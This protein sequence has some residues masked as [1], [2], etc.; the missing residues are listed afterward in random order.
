MFF[1]FVFFFLPSSS[2]G[3]ESYETYRNPALLHRKSG[4]TT[5]YPALRLDAVCWEN[6]LNFI[7]N[8]EFK[9]FVCFL[10]VQKAF[11][12]VWHKNPFDAQQDR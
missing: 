3:G 1:F 12:S 2:N 5:G 6:A 11:D 4:V 7:R 8:S 10:N 9:L